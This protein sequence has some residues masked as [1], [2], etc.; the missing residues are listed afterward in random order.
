MLAFQTKRVRNQ[1]RKSVEKVRI[2]KIWKHNKIQTP[3][4]MKKQSIPRR[5]MIL[6]ITKIRLQKIKALVETLM[7]VRFW[8]RLEM[9]VGKGRL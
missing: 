1:K 5:P 9:R 6:Q 2:L 3:V 8:R 7:E 4:L